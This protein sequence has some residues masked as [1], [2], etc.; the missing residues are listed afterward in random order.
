LFIQSRRNRLYARFNLSQI[1]SFLTKAQV[2]IPFTATHI[3]ISNDSKKTNATFSFNG[4][5]IDGELFKKETPITFD[6]CADNRIWFFRDGIASDTDDSQIRV[7]A[8][9]L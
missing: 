2:E 3:I 7:W 5:A 9:R 1:G 8:W 4:V 6:G